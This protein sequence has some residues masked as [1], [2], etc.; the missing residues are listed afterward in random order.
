MTMRPDPLVDEHSLVLSRACIELARAQL[1]LHED[2]TPARRAAVT[3][4]RAERDALRYSYA[5]P[6]HSRRTRIRTA[7]LRRYPRQPGSPLF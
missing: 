6:P 3:T 7:R 1:Q 2:D 4:C 5:D